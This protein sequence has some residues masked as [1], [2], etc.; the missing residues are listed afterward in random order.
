[1]PGQVSFS[2]NSPK[3]CFLTNLIILTKAGVIISVSNLLTFLGGSGGGEGSDQ[4]TELNPILP[5][6]S[7]VVCDFLI[8]TNKHKT[9]IYRLISK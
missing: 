7:R 3:L 8:K 5:K 4:S 1:M 2:L 6:I 9:E